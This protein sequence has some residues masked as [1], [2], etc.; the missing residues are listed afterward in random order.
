MTAMVQTPNATPTAANPLFEERARLQSDYRWL[1]EARNILQRQYPNRYIAI[2]NREVVAI[3][4][5]INLLMKELA[6][7][8]LRIDKVAVEHLSNHPLCFLL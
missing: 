1:A 4:T 6:K 3:E 8:G 7:K 5:N 2:Q